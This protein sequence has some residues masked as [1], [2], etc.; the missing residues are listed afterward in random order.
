MLICDDCSPDN[1]FAVIEQYALTLQQRF[2]HVEIL[3]NEV[4]CGV[5]ANINRMLRLANGDYIKIIASDDAMTENAIQI[6]VDYFLAHPETDV[7]ITNGQRVSEEQR[8]PHFISNDLIYSQPP[9]LSGADLFRRIAA[10]NE[11]FAPGAILR[12]DVYIQ[13]GLY[14][15]T[16]AVE[17][18]EFWLRLLRTGQVCFGYIHTPLIYY[19]INGSSMTSTVVNDALQKRRERFH[20]A[21]MQ[22][23]EK[24]RADFAKDDFAQL[25]VTRILDEMSFAIDRKMDDWEQKLQW[26]LK[27]FSARKTL[28]FS[29]RCSLYRRYARMQLR[30]IIKRRK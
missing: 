1:S 13:Y 9:M 7:L 29:N 23:Y 16:L 15:E 5:T 27:T 3:H 25:T 10:H 4:N 21:I 30:K 6:M 24:Y 20:N 26:Q 22:T 17:D 28:S 8:Y 2:S 14:D 11:I 18:L 19:R 12:K